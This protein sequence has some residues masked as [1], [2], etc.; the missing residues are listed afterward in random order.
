MK[1]K[2]F[3]HLAWILLP[4]FLVELAHKIVFFSK[5]TV[6]LPFL[7]SSTSASIA[8][9]TI[10]AV[11]VLCSWVY[12]TGVFLLVCVLF[13][14]TCELQILRFEGFRKLFEVLDSDESAIFKEHV[15]IRTQ[16]SVTSHRYRFFII[17][18][19]IIIT[20]SQ[21][22]ALLAVLSSTEAKTFFNSGDLVVH[23]LYTIII[24]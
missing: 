13:R 10:L 22:G 1:Y 14:L 19:L 12:R 24:R 11:L 18:C 9:K 2:T 21:F 15:R 6:S 4:S 17:G 23:E 3:R 7:T 16:L 20:I 5:V 8:A